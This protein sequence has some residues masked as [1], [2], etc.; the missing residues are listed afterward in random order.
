MKIRSPTSG[1]GR[2][3]PPLKETALIHVG[4][5][6]AQRGESGALVPPGGGGRSGSTDER[7]PA[8][9]L[10]F[11]QTRSRDKGFTGRKLFAERGSQVPFG[12]EGKPGCG[13]PV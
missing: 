2:L 10:P 7:E 6:R 9:L 1:L 3:Q 12:V 4:R 8:S 13:I 5:V 11:V